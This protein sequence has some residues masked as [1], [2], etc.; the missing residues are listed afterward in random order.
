MHLGEPHLRG[1]NN[2][3]NNKKTARRAWCLQKLVRVACHAHPS[4]NRQAAGGGAGG[5]GL[6]KQALSVVLRRRAWSAG[7]RRALMRGHRAEG[8]E[9]QSVQGALGARGTGFLGQSVEGFVTSRA[10]ET[11][12]L[13]LSMPRSR[14]PFQVALILPFL[15]LNIHAKLQPPK[16]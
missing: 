15:A 2:N 7:R 10:P 14:E 11:S 9:L 6:A 8:A 1:E 13:F 16:D 12:A 5:R 3:N 4:L